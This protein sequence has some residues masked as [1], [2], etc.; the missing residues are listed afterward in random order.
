MPSASPLAAIYQV[1]QQVQAHAA[2]NAALF[3]NNEAATRAALI[4]PILRALG[5]DTTNVRMVEPERMVA[6]KQSL[7]YVL[8]DAHGNIRSVV[9]AK[10]L[11]ESLDKLGHVGAVIG[12]AFSLKPKNF[13]I[14]D[15]LNWHCY[16]PAHS[17]FH[18]IE[19]ID[20]RHTDLVEAALRLIQWLDATQAGHG[21]SVPA[22]P[23]VPSLVNNVELPLAN[24]KKPKAPKATASLKRTQ[25]HLP[26]AGFTDLAQ[27]HLL[28]LQPGQKP[29]QLRLA[30]GTI[31][32]IAT[33]KDILLE[34]CRF[35]FATNPHIPVPFV[36]KA[37]KKTF[38]FSAEKPSNG[39]STLAS[40]NS[41]PVFIYTN[42]SAADCITNALYAAEQIPPHHQ[43]AAFAVSF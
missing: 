29:K 38:L 4:N 18:P 11:G 34:V 25:P 37:G 39:S 21:I 15:G 41:K 32:P 7:D 19:T 24:G 27:V 43:K 5:W 20:F 42:Y 23:A 17:T 33:W 28:A 3:Q 9:E 10:K 22:A 36:D 14:T 40:Y 26:S 12:Y 2:A 31:Q 16:S 6:N 30:D 8:K 13:F 1:I 35:A